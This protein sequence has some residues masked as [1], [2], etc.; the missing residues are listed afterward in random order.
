MRILLCM[1]VFCSLVGTAKGAEEKLEGTFFGKNLYV[2]NKSDSKPGEQCVNSVSVNG[3]NIA[4]PV[5]STS[6]EIDFEAMGFKPGEKVTVIIKTNGNCKVGIIN[7]EVLKAYPACDY[8]YIKADKNSVNWSTKGENGE[9]PFLIQQYKWSRWVT[10]GEVMGKGLP[11]S[12]AYSY[13][14]KHMFGVNQYRVMQQDEEGRMGSSTEV[15]S[16]SSNPDITYVNNKGNSIG[17]SEETQYEIYDAAG[18]LILEGRGTGI[19][20]SSL[21]KG[22]YHL[23]YANKSEI[24]KK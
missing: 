5:S 19:D 6:F 16:R 22:D 4:T 18:N 14:V 8:V 9:L 15:T 11:D 23:A 12:T 7:P 24:F 1:F 21:A 2:V 10:I 20:I 17:F 13:Q 3:K